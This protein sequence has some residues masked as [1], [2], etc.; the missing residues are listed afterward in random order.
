MTTEADEVA[1]LDQA[2]AQTGRVIASVGDDGWSLATPCAGW[3]VAEVVRHLVASIRMMRVSAEGGTPQRGQSD[4]VEG[5]LVA[6]YREAA[7]GLLDAWSSPGALESTRDFGGHPV[8]AAFALGVHRIEVVIHGWDVAAARGR[9]GELDPVL[10]EIAL[11]S[12]RA[13][14]RPEFRGTA[15]EGKHFG[16][17][18]PVPEDAPAYDRLA[19]W[20]GRSPGA[21]QRL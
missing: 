18:V 7:A 16:P 1:T 11:A 17:E 20:L 6:A 14:L 2:L 4:P 9:T 3:D 21:S 15:A 8:P 12:S 13:M 5:D 10:A 19:G